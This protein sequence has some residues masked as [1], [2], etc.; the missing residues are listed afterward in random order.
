[1][2]EILKGKGTNGQLEL[3]EHKLVIKRKGL[4]NKMLHGLKGDKEIS[5][6]EIT[7]IQYKKPGLVAGY[8]QFSFRGGTEAQGGVWQAVSD[9]NTIT[10]NPGQNKNF[11]KIKEEI[12]KRINDLYAT[13]TVTQ[14]T[15]Q[16]LNDYD[17]I[18]RLASLMEKGY[19]T[20]EEFQ[21]KKKQILG[22]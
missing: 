2:S 13:P 12:E 22:L 10:F 15:N 5:I 21:A 1:M 16:N 19:I 9:E 3:H 7:S 11:L 20:D 18:E 14:P 8:I 4:T 17:E 6:R